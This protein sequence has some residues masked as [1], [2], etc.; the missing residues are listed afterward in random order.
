VSQTL[1]RIHRSLKDAFDPD[2]VFNP[3]RLYADL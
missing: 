2:R 1:M 3:G